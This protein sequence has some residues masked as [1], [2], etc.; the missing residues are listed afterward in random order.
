[1]CF[2]AITAWSVSVQSSIVPMH[3]NPVRQHADRQS[4]FFASKLRTHGLACNLWAG[5]STDPSDWMYRAQR[6]HLQKKL[7]DGEQR[8]QEAKADRKENERDRKMREAVT[9]MKRLFPG[10]LSTCILCDR[11][12]RLREI[13]WELTAFYIHSLLLLCKESLSSTT[14]WP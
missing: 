12:T 10:G 3:C 2:A 11:L 7:Y 9:N 4:M 14:Q 5:S 6:D 8:L 13:T 1:M